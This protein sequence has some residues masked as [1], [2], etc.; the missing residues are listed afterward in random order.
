[1]LYRLVS[2]SKD[3]LV[4]DP[5]VFQACW[6]HVVKYLP[7][8]SGLYFALDESNEYRIV[9]FDTDK[10]VWWDKNFYSMINNIRYWM[11]LPEKPKEVEING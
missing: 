10:K 3:I 4:D 8:K 6:I 7:W 9:Y 11:P 2:P 5:L 1:M